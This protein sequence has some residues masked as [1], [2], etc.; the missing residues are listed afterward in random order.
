MSLI[1]CSECNS[2]ISENASSCPHCGNPIQKERVFVST[3]KENPVEIELTSKRWKRVIL[4]AWI[5]IIFSLFLCSIA[6]VSEWL[7][8]TIL[9]VFILIIG[10]IGAW[11]SNR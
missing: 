6:R 8:L 11:Y 4:F 1:K 10:K 5:V 3:E 7:G 2:E 9:G